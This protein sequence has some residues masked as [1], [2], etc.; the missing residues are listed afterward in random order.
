M[1][2][3][4]LLLTLLFLSFNGNAETT[5]I[6]KKVINAYGGQTLLNASSLKVVDHNKGPW[7][8]ETENPGVPEIWRINESLIIDFQ[9][10]RKSLLSYRVPRTTI[11][12][13]KWIYDGKNAYI[14]DV[15]HQKYSKEDWLNYNNLGGSLVRSSDTMHAKRLASEV[16]K[17]NYVGEEFY[18][19][20]LHKKLAVTFESG[21]QFIYFIDP[22]SALIKKIYRSLP[23]N[24]LVY[25]F[26]NHLTKQGLSYAADMNFFVDGQLRLSSVHRDIELNPSLNTAFEKPTNYKPWGEMID[27]RKM[28]SKKI[29]DGIYQAGIGRSKTVFIEQADHFIALG[30]AR[31]LK[32]NFKEIKNLTN[33]EKPIN[34]F[35]V[36]H[37]HRRNLQGLDD[38]AALG[39]KF[40]AAKAHQDTI[41]QSL[42]HPLASDK[43]VVIPNRKPFKLGNV[44]LYDIATTHSQHYLLV[45]SEKNKM[46][47]AEEHYEVQLTQQKPRIYKDM[48]IFANALKKLNIQVNSLVDI[49]SWR[50]ITIDELYQWTGDFKEKS[51]PAEYAICTSTAKR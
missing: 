5:N 32:D 48:V 29:G 44:T 41:N 15:L 12:L 2:K 38:I 30:S 47:I 6:I 3:I 31:K 20:T 39:A 33:T 36:T 27:N 13:E 19:G 37:H 8:G 14:Y 35:V 40:V 11:D 23:N 34:Y 1:K 26:S 9:N 28:I 10:K 51:C 45:Q 49:N 24:N 7:P 25:V 43:F 22:K 50:A 18:R 21:N 42:K 16:T 46:V 4:T 17:A